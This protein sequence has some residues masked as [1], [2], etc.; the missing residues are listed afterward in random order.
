MEHDTAYW[1][2][3]L[4]KDAYAVLREKGTEAPFSGKFVTFNES[5]KFVCAGCGSELFDSETKFDS[6][7]GWPSFDAAKKDA[8]NFHEDTSLG[9]KRV[10]VTCKKCGGHLGHVFNDGPTKTGERFCIN[11]VALDFKKGGKK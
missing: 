2:K 6:H 8:V 7:C 5:G 1:K 10:E 9:M 3:K 4:S 11:S